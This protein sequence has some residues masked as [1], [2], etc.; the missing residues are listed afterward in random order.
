MKNI[1][2][3]FI[4][5]IYF[6]ILTGCEKTKDSPAPEFPP[7]SS[8]EMEGLTLFTSKLKSEES[9]DSSNF[10]KAHNFIRIWDSI[11]IRLVRV[12][13]V[14]LKEVKQYTPEALFNTE[15]SEWEWQ[16][17][18]DMT[19][20]GQYLATLTATTFEDSIY[21]KMK[22]SRIGGEGF[23]NFTWFEGKCN[24]KNTGGWWKINEPIVKKT[25]LF[26][27]WDYNTETEK[28]IKYTFIADEESNKGSY[29]KYGVLNSQGYNS[30]FD[31]F[32]VS[33]SLFAKIEWNKADFSGKL[34]INQG[35]TYLWDAY[36]KNN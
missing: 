15:T 35:I 4:A 23:N 36:G 13:K 28:W 17:I 24:F 25:F 6:V 33:S 22:V 14:L 30:Y 21:W 5:I 9:K 12:P 29:I 11:A 27:Q 2:L 20:D 8:V 19:G 32:F 7:L 1:V 34:T 26:I 31:I 18:K 3:P 16:F 10:F